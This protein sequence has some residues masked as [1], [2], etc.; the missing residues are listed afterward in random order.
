MGEVWRGTDRQLGRPVAVKVMRDQLADP[1]LVARFQ[2]EARIAAQL[3]HPGITVVHD[4]GEQ[5][6]QPFIVME[7]LDGRDLASMLE[8]TPARRLP[9][10]TAVSLTVQAARALQ[11][12]HAR[13]VIH[14]DLK[15][16]NL[17]LQNN[18]LLKIC[19]FGI[20]RIA[21]ATDGLTSAGYA[22]GTACYMSPEQCE[23]KQVDGRS[24]LYSLGC[25]LYE[26]LTGKPPFRDGEPLA[27]MYD[28]RYTPPVDLRTLRP[29]IPRELDILV[30]NMLAK[31]PDARPSSADD[32]AAA[33]KTVT[34]SSAGDQTTVSGADVEAE[35]TLSF[36]EAVA[37][38]TVTLTVM[39]RTIR[40][41][42]PAGVKDGQKVRLR[43]NG[44]PKE[45]GGP[46][47]DL[48]VQVHVKPQQPVK[49]A[50]THVVDPHERGTFNTVKAAI[51]AAE[52][53]DRIS[54]R[55]GLYEEGLVIDKPLEI[56]GDGPASDIEI[57]ARY[58][59]VLVFQAPTGRISNLT[60]R[61]TGGRECHGVDI[62]QGQLHLDGCDI[63]SQSAACVVIRD[64]A[65]P[66]LRRNKIHDGMKSGVLI[67]DG[68][69][70]TLEDNDITGNAGSGVQIRNSANP[71]LRRNQ[72]LGNEKSGVFVYDGGQGT[73]E[74]N[75]ITGNGLVGVS[76]RTGSVIVRGNRI[77]RN[78]REA[79]WVRERGRAVV[80]DNDLRDNAGGA[81]DISFSAANVTRARNN[82]LCAA[83]ADS[84]PVL[85]A[86]MA[87]TV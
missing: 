3:Q 75:D 50:R 84:R 86:T 27:I 34:R 40:V 7:L 69:L 28:H 19:D 37:G 82:E 22:I 65:N 31:T 2:R 21:D 60:L 70:G 83:V 11:A 5:D 1:V 64:G 23:G 49:S 48:Y 8:Q 72:I 13:H 85:A 41:R 66:L 87:P 30:L 58:V 63:S 47:G 52:P 9:I 35:V 76:V 54:V 44:A 4:V 71:T 43:S 36:D 61:Q 33:L 74:D 79:V 59:H 46:A 68:G 62:R 67:C 17:F 25:V 24:D 16:A 42:I 6:G 10:D 45:H 73:L 77:N 53:G 18:G 38:A 20:A 12:A 80:E 78:G 56:F 57:R 81:W 39:N 26:L 32:V 14:R 55:P 29:D 51:K 15:P